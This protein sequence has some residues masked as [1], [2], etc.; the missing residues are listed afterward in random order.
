MLKIIKGQIQMRYFRLWLYLKGNNCPFSAY[1]F[2]DGFLVPKGF[3]KECEY[4]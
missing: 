4:N 1:P 3:A 2:P